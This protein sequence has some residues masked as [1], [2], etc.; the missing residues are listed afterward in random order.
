[1]RRWPRGTESPPK[2]PRG[3]WSPHG[4]GATRRRWGRRRPE[5]AKA[6][7]QA[8]E[9][10]TSGRCRDGE[11]GAS[12]AMRQHPGSVPDGGLAS[13]PL[14]AR[15]PACLPSPQAAFPRHATGPGQRSPPRTAGGDQVVVGPAPGGA[16]CPPR[17]P[18]Q[19]PRGPRWGAGTA[20]PSTGAPG[21]RALS[22]RPSPP[23]ATHVEPPT[24]APR[25]APLG[26][27]HPRREGTAPRRTPSLGTGLGRQVGA[28]DRRRSPRTLLLGGER[29]PRSPAAVATARGADRGDR[30]GLRADLSGG[31][32]GQ[33]AG[34]PWSPSPQQRLAPSGASRRV[35]TR[36]PH[37]RPTPRRQR[38]PAVSPERPARDGRSAASG[39]PAGPC[40]RLGG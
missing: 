4:G 23:A 15:S 22:R 8:L 7:G 17:E 29:S 31:P 14:D 20:P 38:R 18:R 24:R 3:G 12:A 11:R 26:H 16:S 32:M 25:Q 37:R 40:H 5:E 21:H 27:S 6:R 39:G 28:A 30:Q 9:T 1:M 13:H 19:T 34:V 35:P 10:L 33:N 2:R 36:S